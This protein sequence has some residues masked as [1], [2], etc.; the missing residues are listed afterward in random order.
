MVAGFLPCGAAD[1]AAIASMQL[2]AA[3][4]T[5][6]GQLD[7]VKVFSHHLAPRGCLVSEKAVPRE[8][9]AVAVLYCAGPM[10]EC[11]RV[12]VLA[13]RAVTSVATGAARFRS[14]DVLHVMSPASIACSIVGHRLS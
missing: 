7:T 8:L 12:I 11:E 9:W 2:N 3:R 1:Y 14:F 6:P 10:S 4:A 13:I 5:L